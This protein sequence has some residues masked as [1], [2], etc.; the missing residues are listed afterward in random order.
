MY[1]DI[2]NSIKANSIILLHIISF[3]QSNNPSITKE[4][5]DLC[6][7]VLGAKHISTKDLYCFFEVCNYFF[8]GCIDENHLKFYI[9]KHLV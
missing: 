1:E 8:H 6:K 3:N 7:K 2:K 9:N 4:T 5:C